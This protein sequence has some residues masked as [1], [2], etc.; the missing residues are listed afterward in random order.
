MFHYWETYTVTVTEYLSESHLQDIANSYKD[1]IK[2]HKKIY[3]NYTE[4]YDSFSDYVIEY[5]S[6]SKNFYGFDYE[7]EDGNI[8]ELYNEI[9]KYM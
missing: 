6:L 2:R 9:K 5:L 1:Y 3:P 4:S 7:Y 8:E